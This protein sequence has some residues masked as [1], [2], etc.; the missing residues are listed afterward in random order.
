[1]LLHFLIILPS[2]DLSDCSIFLQFLLLFQV[3]FILAR[4]RSLDSVDLR[5]GALL[6]RKIALH[7][8][9]HK[10]AR[11]KRNYRRHLLQLT[12][13]LLWY[14]FLIFLTMNICHFTIIKQ[15]NDQLHPCTI[16]PHP[17]FSCLHTL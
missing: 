4:F 5:F 9:E 8:H 10:N 15:C 16:K 12:F 6:P 14:H 11:K 17:C 2:L 3:P 13:T 1:M 7:I